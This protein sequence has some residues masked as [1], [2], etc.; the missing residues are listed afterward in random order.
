MSQQHLFTE[1]YAKTIVQQKNSNHSN[2]DIN[3]VSSIAWNMDYDGK[4]AKIDMKLKRNDNRKHI[5]VELNN[6]DLAELL[7]VQSIEKPLEKRLMD[8][9]GAFRKNTFR[10]NTFRKSVQNQRYTHSNRSSRRR[11]TRRHYKIRT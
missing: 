6:Q 4:K 9:F 11:R 10:K 1:G 8:D 2:D 5:N 3:N 7:N